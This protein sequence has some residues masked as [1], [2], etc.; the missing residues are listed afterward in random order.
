M[1][2]KITLSNTLGPI[3]A[4]KEVS[5]KV[6]AIIEFFRNPD[7]KEH[8]RHEIALFPPSQITPLKHYYRYMAYIQ[9]YTEFHKWVPVL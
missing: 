8:R 3:R 1:V 2:I 5:R 6:K 7:Y 4:E 9:A